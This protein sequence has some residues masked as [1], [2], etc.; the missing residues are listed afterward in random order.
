MFDQL[1]KESINRIIDIELSEV[2]KRIESL[3]FHVR[4]TDEAKEYIASKGYDVQFGARPLKRAIQKYVEDVLAEI[5]LE[6]SV[7]EGD[8]ILIGYDAE[9]NKMTKVFS[10]L[11]CSSQ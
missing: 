10:G 4:I 1:D 9:N 8:S 7:T 11:R 5:L 6:D 2:Y 3:G